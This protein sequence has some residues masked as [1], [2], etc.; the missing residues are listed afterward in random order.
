MHMVA[1]VSSLGPSTLT[2]V[3]TCWRA[4]GQACAPSE[5]GLLLPI[6]EPD[7]QGMQW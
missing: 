1:A 7:L 4:A 6:S 3:Y 2:S 5:Q